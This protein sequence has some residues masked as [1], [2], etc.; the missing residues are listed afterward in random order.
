MTTQPAA[1]ARAWVPFLLRGLLGSAAP[2]GGHAALCSGFPGSRPGL[3]DP[4]ADP[5]K[6][7]DSGGARRRVGRLFREADSHPGLDA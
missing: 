2:P 4:A 3:R 7:G 6:A 5:E 1:C